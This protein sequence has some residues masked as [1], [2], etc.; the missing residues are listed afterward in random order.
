[1]VD[2]LAEIQ[3]SQFLVKVLNLP[4]HTRIYTITMR[5]PRCVSFFLS[6]HIV[7]ELYLGLLDLES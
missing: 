2:G 5:S 6:S 4:V 1:M 3:N 7:H